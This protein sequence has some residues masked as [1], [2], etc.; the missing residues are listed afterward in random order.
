MTS[1]T[2]QKPIRLTI[3]VEPHVHQV[4]QRFAKAS[5]MSLGKLMGEWLGDTV[6]AAEFTAIKVEQARSAPAAAMRE[7]HAYALGMVDETSQLMSQIRAKGVSDRAQSMLDLAG[8]VGPGV[9]DAKRPRRPDSIIPPSSN[10]GG[11]GTKPKT[12][13]RTS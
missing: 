10:T 3:T 13:G 2:T 11:K 7:M 12:K 8:K 4:F 6:E 1:T 5:G 9:G